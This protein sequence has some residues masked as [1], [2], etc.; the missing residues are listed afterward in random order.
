MKLNQENVYF[1][2]GEFAKCANISIRT[3]RYYDKIGILPPSKLTDSGYRL[4]TN[5]DFL[6]LQKILALKFFDFSLEEIESMASSTVDRESFRDSLH[7]QKQLLQSKINQLEMIKC[8]IDQA[9]DML[10]S[11]TEIGWD[12][13]TD[14]IHAMTMKQSIRENYKNADHLNVRILLH[15]KYSKNPQGWYP[16]LASHIPFAKNQKILELGCGNGAFWVENEAI[17]PDK[18]SITITDISDG[19]IKVAK[20]AIDQ[21]GLSCTYDVLDINHLNFTKESFDLIIANHVLFYANDRNK[22]CEDIA[23]ILK[24]NGVFVCT[25]YGQQ[26]MKEIEQITKKFNPK[27]ALSEIN[28]SDLFGLENAMD[29]LQP[30]FSSVNKMDYKDSLILDDYRPLLHYVLSCHGNQIEVLHGHRKEFEY[31]LAELFRQKRQVEITKQ[32]GMFLC[33]K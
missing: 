4:Y 29:Y 16:F 5:S 24:P 13:I 11:E 18:L 27:I 7:L 30:H 15:K 3:L 10:Q 23:R 22:V 8:T 9:E 2:V 33:R 1:T 26:H 32:A 28:L 31:Y 21:T 12:K 20:E 17:L 14:I 25:A 19:M 6:K